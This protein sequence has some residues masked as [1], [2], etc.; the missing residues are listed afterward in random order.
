[1]QKSIAGDNGIIAS[2]I[3]APCVLEGYT[4]LLKKL[5][6]K[7]RVLLKPSARGSRGVGWGSDAGLQVR[8]ELAS[9]DCILCLQLL[10]VV[11]V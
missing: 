4:C 9:I 8:A 1:M 2:G 7:L 11:L 10:I 6:R 3:T 5:A